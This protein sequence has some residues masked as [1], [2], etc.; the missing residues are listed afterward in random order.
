MKHSITSGTIGSLYLRTLTTGSSG[1]LTLFSHWT[2]M[3]SR[4]TMPTGW[5][6]SMKRS[7]RARRDSFPWPNIRRA[8]PFCSGLL[9]AVAVQGDGNTLAATLIDNGHPLASTHVHAGTPPSMALPKRTHRVSAIAPKEDRHLLE[10]LGRTWR[11]LVVVHRFPL[12]EYRLDVWVLPVLRGQSEQP[13][14]LGGSRAAIA[15]L[16]ARAIGHLGVRLSAH[17]LQPGQCC[18]HDGGHRRL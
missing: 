1:G 2:V 10:W 14:H 9:D 3:G 8:A 17:G 16:P 7:P 5:C 4:P 18:G 6:S 12:R 11:L 13:V 15:L